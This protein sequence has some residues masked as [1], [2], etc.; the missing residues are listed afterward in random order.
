M[1]DYDK[2]EESNYSIYEDANNL[3]EV[4]RYGRIEFVND[5]DVEKIL[6]TLDGNNTGYIIQVDKHFPI[7][8][9]DKF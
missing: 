3:S 9:H 8:L 7:E 6:K 4:L 2:N 5:F 1:P